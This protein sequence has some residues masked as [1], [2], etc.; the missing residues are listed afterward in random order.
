MGNYAS[1]IIFAIT[2]TAPLSGFALLI[3]LS[4]V[5]AEAT[6]PAQENLASIATWL[7]PASWAAFL[8]HLAARSQVN[9]K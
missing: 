2:T 3:W 1:S 7:I 5:P 8:G 9:R 4:T 6:T